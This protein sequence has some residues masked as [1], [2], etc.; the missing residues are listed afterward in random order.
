M[1]AAQDARTWAAE[2]QADGYVAKPFE[3]GHLLAEVQRLC[4]AA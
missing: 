4:A 1:T 3:L 2:I